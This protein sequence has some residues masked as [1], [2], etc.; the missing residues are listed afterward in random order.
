LAKEDLTMTITKST[1]FA[2]GIVSLLAFAT[3][4]LANADVRSRQ[5]NLDKAAARAGNG[6]VTELQR[7]R[8]ELRRDYAEL[9]RDRADLRR[10]Q[11]SGASRQEIIRKRQ[12][13]NGDL[14]EIAQ[15]RREIREDLG[16]LR[17]DRD[18]GT[19]W[20]HDGWQRDRWG[21]N[22]NRGWDRGRDRRDNRGWG[23]NHDRFGWGYG[24]D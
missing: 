8:A 15:D 1:L 19:G 2:A 6:R 10:L 20:G 14:R 24:R 11:R 22:D 7:D 12:E 16:A 13:I 18:H 9:E 23:N 21:R 4:N 5:K 17:R 3:A